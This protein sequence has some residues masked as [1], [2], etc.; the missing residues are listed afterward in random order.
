MNKY[1]RDHQLQLIAVGELLADARRGL[2]MQQQR[3]VPSDTRLPLPAP[4]ALDI[5]HAVAWLRDTLKWTPASLPAIYPFRAFLAV[6][7]NYTF[8]SVASKPASN[9]SP[10]T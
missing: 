1:F 5:L 6:C 8:F 4:V 7:D 10:A 3:L 9:V 2:E